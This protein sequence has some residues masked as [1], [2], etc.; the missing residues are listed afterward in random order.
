MAI[1][2]VRAGSGFNGAISYDMEKDGAEHISQSGVYGTTPDEMAREMRMVANMRSLKEPVWHASLSLPP[3]EHAT[4]QQMDTLGR[5]WLK[6][7]GFDLDK[8]QFVIVRHKDR[9]H[10]HIHITVNRVQLDGSVVDDSFYKWR[11]H[12]ACRVAER[13]AGLSAFDERTQSKGGLLHDLRQ[14]V[15]QAKAAADG[16]LSR[17][18]SSLEAQGLKLVEHRA[19][20][21]RMQGV[22]YETPDGRIYKGSAL[23]KA[24]AA[25]GLQK[26]GLD[27]GYQPGK[28]KAQQQGQEQ[29]QRHGGT[30]QQYK[31]TSTGQAA[32]AGRPG[33]DRTREPQR[34]IAA[35]R[36]INSIRGEIWNKR[37]AAE[38]AKDEAAQ[39]RKQRVAED[40]D[41]M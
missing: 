9:P 26:S 6:E 35:A 17:F 10:E 38:Q 21:G 29:G 1:A 15:D 19:S 31:D 34:Q 8:A 3:G 32:R 23:G 11:S 25:A 36:D 5:T 28:P 2:D 27:L 16:D 7:M 22:S 33:A 40:E 24:Y 30:G 20:T 4:N 39:R 12:A 18:K 13:E 14:A 41:E 37:R